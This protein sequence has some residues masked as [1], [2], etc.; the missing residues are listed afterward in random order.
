MTGWEQSWEHK[1]IILVYIFMHMYVSGYHV[2]NNSFNSIR[3]QRFYWTI[4]NNFLLVFEYY[5]YCKKKSLFLVQYFGKAHTHT[6]PSTTASCFLF[7]P[8]LADNRKKHTQKQNEIANELYLLLFFFFLTSSETFSCWPTL[9]CTYCTKYS[10]EK[11][12][13]AEKICI[14]V[15]IPSRGYCEEGNVG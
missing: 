10:I 8:T 13:R 5:F 7:P 4:I 6:T 1:S 3:P 9:C 15:G 11:Q 12:E 14:K 2:F